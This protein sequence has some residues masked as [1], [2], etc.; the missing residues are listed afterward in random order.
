M[1]RFELNALW[2]E[3]C[4][5]NMRLVFREL[6][7]LSSSTVLQ[8]Q[9]FGFHEGG[10]ASVYFYNF[11]GKRY[12]ITLHYANS[13]GQNGTDIS[14]FISN[15]NQVQTYEFCDNGTAGCI[16]NDENNVSEIVNYFFWTKITIPIQY[17]LLS[18][19][20]D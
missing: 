13:V 12:Q 9:T 1:F 10:K 18:T 8:L 17:E 6:R 4:C 2:S 15:L 19:C 16:H 3:S 5:Q 7:Q 20:R 14:G 11:T